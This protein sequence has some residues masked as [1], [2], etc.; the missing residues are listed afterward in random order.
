MAAQAGPSNPLKNRSVRQNTKSAPKS[1]KV[2]KL[3]EK[4]RIIELER[5][6]A[7]FV[8]R[9]YSLVSTDQLQPMSGSAK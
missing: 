3:S 8:S 5:A 2:K 9:D 6:A 1:G 7:E 4:H